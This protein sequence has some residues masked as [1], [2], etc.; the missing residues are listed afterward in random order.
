MKVYLLGGVGGRS[1]PH[2]FNLAW[3]RDNITQ[4]WLFKIVVIFYCNCLF[5]FRLVFKLLVIVIS[6]GK[7]IFP[8]GV[9]VL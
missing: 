3:Y 1:P 4:S 9:R 8:I 7:S 2:V 6:Q 5:S